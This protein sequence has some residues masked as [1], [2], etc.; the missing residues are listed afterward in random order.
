METV[1]FHF[2]NLFF[3][4]PLELGPYRLR[5]AGDLAADR[6]FRCERHRQKWHELSYILSGTAEFVC[7][8]EAVKVKQGDLI[9]NSRGS[10]HTISGSVEEPMRYTY[11]AFEI[12][13]CSRQEER[14]L[15]D[16]Y[17]SLASCKVAADSAISGAFMEILENFL[18][19]DAFFT[20]LTEDALRRLLV[21]AMRAFSGSSRRV[22][23]PEGHG[24]KSGLLSGI[25]RSIDA[26]PDNI[27]ILS[28]LP[29]RLGYS[30]SYLSGLFSKA[31]GMSMRQ[32]YQM[33]RHEQACTLLRAGHS[34]TAVAEKQGYG[35]VHAF[36]HAFAARQGV[37]PSIYIK[38]K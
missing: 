19:R 25:C 8:D 5:Q 30:Y 37:P 14:W 32:Y 16:F 22:R 31:M 17:D 28:E 9:F 33:R 2:D 36:S 10:F 13:D 6:G 24:D 20:R 34:V 7:D 35:S 27:H 21:C 11:I 4:D 1:R 23:I 18:N 12:A 26:D 3:N 15:S 38:E 29:E